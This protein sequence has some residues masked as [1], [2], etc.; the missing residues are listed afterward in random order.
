MCFFHGN[1]YMVRTRIEKSLSRCLYFSQK[2][3]KW[4]LFGLKQRHQLN[5]FSQTPIDLHSNVRTGENAHIGE[6]GW[7]KI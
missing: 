6:Q 5:D 2:S 3:I 4:T 1:F 7:V